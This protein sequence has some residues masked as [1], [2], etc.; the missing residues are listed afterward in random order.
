MPAIPTEGTLSPWAWT[1]RVLVLCFALLGLALALG[2]PF[3]F[4]WLYQ[5]GIGIAA[6][7]LAFKIYNSTGE[8]ELTDD[9]YQLLMS[10][11]EHH[12]IPMVIDA[13]KNV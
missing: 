4:A 9:E 1:K 6:H 11:A 3:S 7:A 8:C 12:F 5:S 2:M 10:F 13:L